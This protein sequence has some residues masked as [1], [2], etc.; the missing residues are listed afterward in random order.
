MLKNDLSPPL[1]FLAPP[2]KIQKRSWQKVETTQAYQNC[3]IVEKVR[4]I[5]PSSN[6]E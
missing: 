3:H 6:K 2:R 4:I 5:T 1:R